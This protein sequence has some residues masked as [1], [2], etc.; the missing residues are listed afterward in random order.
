MKRCATCRHWKK[1]ADRG[2]WITDPHDPDTFEPMQIEFEVR[3]CTHPKLEF[4]E[5]PLER[6][7]FAVADGS[8]YFAALFTAEDFGCVRH[9]DAE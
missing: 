5:R 8:E 2:Q 4:C 3:E 9:E 1:P 6:D 7:G